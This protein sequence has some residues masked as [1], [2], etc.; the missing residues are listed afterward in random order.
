MATIFSLLCSACGLSHREAA[1]LLGV[2]LD[3]AKKW[4]S[5]GR[6]PPERVLLELAGLAERIDAAADGALETIDAK[7]E[8]IAT[9]PD[10][11]ELG[12]AADDAEAQSLGWPCVGAHRAVLAMVVSRGMAE[13]YTFQIVPR[14]STAV[15]AGVADEHDRVLRKKH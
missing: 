2:S 12:L 3:T 9:D 13:G 14:G 6:N 7:V 5:G 11:I 4:S 15:T 8:L 1:T 10:V